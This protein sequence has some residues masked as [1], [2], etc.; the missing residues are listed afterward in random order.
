MAKGKKKKSFLKIILIIVAILAVIFIIAALL[1]DDEYSD[2][3]SDYGYTDSEYTGDSADTSSG[4]SSFSGGSQIIGGVEYV[5]QEPVGVYRKF[6]AKVA[7]SSSEE[8]SELAG[9]KHFINQAFDFTEYATTIN[10]SHSGNWGIYIYIC[11]SDLESDGGAATEDINEI[12]NANIPSGSNVVIQAGGASSWNMDVDPNA[13]QRFVYDGSNFS[14]VDSGSKVNM[15]KQK[16]VE[17]FLNFCKNNYP[18]DNEVVI[19]WDHGGASVS[20]ACYDEVFDS[21]HLTLNEIDGAFTNVY[22]KERIE[23]VGFDCCLMATLDTAELLRNHAKMLVASEEL[24]PGNGWYY[25]D[26]LNDLAS[27]PG[28]SN[29]KLGKSICDSFI[30]GCQMVG[31][32]D[33]TTLSAI[34]LTQVNLV[35]GAMNAI[36]A[37][38]LSKATSGNAD[39]FATYGRAAQKSENYGGNN[40]SS[41]YFDMV[42]LGDLLDHCGG[43]L[44]SES[45]ARY[46]L[47]RAVV[48][49]V[50]GSY[51]SESTGIS[52]FYPYDKAEDNMQKI[53]AVTASDIY[54]SAMR[55]AM[56]GQ[57]S[58]E[59]VDLINMYSEK[60]QNFGGIASAS[61]TSSS[62][63]NASDDSE[64]ENYGYDDTE[65]DGSAYD[66]DY[67]DYDGDYDDY[68]DEYRSIAKKTFK[69]A[70]VSVDKLGEVADSLTFK[71]D[72]K[73]IEVTVVDDY[74][75]A[76]I[77]KNID[78]VESVICDFLMYDEAND[79]YIA[80]G[81]D[82][83]VDVDWDN[84]VIRDNFRGVWASLGG[85][86]MYLDI[87]YEGED[88]NL[89]SVPVNVNGKEMDMSVSYDYKADSYKILGLADS[90]DT[91]ASNVSANRVTAKLKAGDKITFIGYILDYDTNEWNETELDTFTY[92]EDMKIT[93]EDLGDGQFAIM[94]IT[95][96]VAG[97]EVYSQYGYIDYYGG[98]IEAYTEDEMD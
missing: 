86:R 55:Y 20:G 66:G 4:N 92:S 87:T 61:A 28:M 8:I 35:T 94:F 36:G 22:G 32:D 89:Y 33:E 88:Y 31:T 73:D 50:H 21:D 6:N 77:G 16:T 9:G 74:I 98:N 82:N 27:D 37:E 49:N 67:D 41:G 78:A 18:A 2:D 1:G 42:D 19:F 14:L 62:S 95:T 79:T 26:W 38:L 93:E 15:G 10:D 11:G 65:Y 68:Y 44:D 7:D 70:N 13:L 46:A 48:Y 5:V 96:D 45:F 80:L 12:L 91:D 17:D 54:T 39:I 40:D 85:H 52:V 75:T 63:N 69:P 97:N 29:A 84:G 25:T 64:Y 23:M 53:E 34:D 30:G 81:Y 59:S 43:V 76:D 47:K 71:N 57:L 72:G 51:R 58:Q 3:G 90:V 24:E 83:D 60:A 56:T